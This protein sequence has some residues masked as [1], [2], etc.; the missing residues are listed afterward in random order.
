MRTFREIF[1][2]IA[3]IRSIRIIF[4]VNLNFL[5]GK[6]VLF[7]MANNWNLVNF[8]NQLCTYTGTINLLVVGD[9]SHNQNLAEKVK[10]AMES[11][12]IIANH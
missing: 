4:N 1:L 11:L 5:R 3:D 12:C 2:Y 10:L 6:Y 9:R 7:L 8:Y